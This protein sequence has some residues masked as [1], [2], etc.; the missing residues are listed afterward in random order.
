MT[1]ET[2]ILISHCFSAL[3]PVT[4]ERIILLINK[5]IWWLKYEKHQQRL[6]K[7]CLYS[8]VIKKCAKSDAKKIMTITITSINDNMAEKQIGLVKK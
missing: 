8:L 6:K 1:T 5:V 3:F 7:F 4:V 2:K